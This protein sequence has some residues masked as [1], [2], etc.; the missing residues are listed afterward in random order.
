[1]ARIQSDKNAVGWV[2]TQSVIT[3]DRMS[4]QRYDSKQNCV[5]TCWK[6]FF[7]KT[8]SGCW[9]LRLQDLDIHSWTEI[10]G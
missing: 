8:T 2:N 3:L 6:Y 9:P 5:L 1:M 7:N 10:C 4:S